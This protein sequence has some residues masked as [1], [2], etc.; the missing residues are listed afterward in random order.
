MQKNAFHRNFQEP[1]GIQKQMIPHVK[2]LMSCNPNLT[3]TQGIAEIA[4]SYLSNN[5]TGWNKRTG[6]NVSQILINVQDG[7]IVQGGK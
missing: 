7:T 3:I 6:R 1:T 5:R 2:V 4:Y